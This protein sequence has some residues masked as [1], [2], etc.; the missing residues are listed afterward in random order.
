[1]GHG[2]SA[3]ARLQM[4]KEDERH[5]AA[6]QFGEFRQLPVK[7]GQGVDYTKSIRQVSP[8]SALETMIRHFTD[9]AEQKR[10]QKELRDTAAA[11]LRRAEEQSIR[12][13]DFSVTMD[14]ILEDH[15]RAAGVSPRGIAPMLNSQQIAELREFAEALSPFSGIRKEFSEAARLAEQGLQQREAPE[16]LIQAHEARTHI[17]PSRP[18]RESTSQATP[19]ADRSD[20][21]SSSRGR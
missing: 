10:E 11:Q 19:S 9:T 13:R 8:R 5:T 1:E 2:N 14:R 12:A 16:A 18:S 3:P 6:W 17:D 15:C 20:R 7:D 4:M 21:D